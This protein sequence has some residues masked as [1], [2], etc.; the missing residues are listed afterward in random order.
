MG[1][2]H[3]RQLI[4]LYKQTTL[5][6]ALLCCLYGLACFFIPSFFHLSNR[7]M[8]IHCASLINMYIYISLPRCLIFYAYMYMYVVCL[9]N[10]QHVHVC[11]VSVQHTACTCMLCIW[12]THSMY[13]YV[14]YLCNTQHV[15]V[16]CVS[17][18]HTA[19]TCMLCICATHS[20]YMYVVYLV[21]T[22][23]VH[24]CC[25]SVQ[26]TAVNVSACGPMTLSV[27]MVRTAVCVEWQ[28]SDSRPPSPTTM[29]TTCLWTMR[30]MYNMYEI[31][32]VYILWVRVPPEAARFSFGKVTAL[33]VLCC[34]ALLFV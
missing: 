8:Y 29:S 25:V 24:V 15:H 30:Y 22:Q 19:C 31:Y 20:M 13:M 1:L 11:C 12:S 2:N 9:Y 23:H 7:Y 5:G 3:P 4:F 28:P 6:V 14:V 32:I 21:N 16:C 18:Q 33:G 26:H 10:R 27:S 17:G 34:F